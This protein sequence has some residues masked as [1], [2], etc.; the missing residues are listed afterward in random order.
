MSGLGAGGGGS[1]TYAAKPEGADSVEVVNR[2]S[3]NS[4]RSVSSSLMIVSTASTSKEF[5]HAVVSTPADYITVGSSFEIGLIGV[6]SAGNTAEIPAGATLRVADTAKGSVA[7]NVFTALAVGRTEI[8]LVLGDKVVGTKT[9]VIIKQPTAL[10]FSEANLNAVYG[11]AKELPLTATYN[12]S[13]VTINPNDIKFSMSNG[14]AGVIDGFCFVGNENSGVRNV[15]VIASLA[16]NRAVTASMSL[17]LYKA[18][19]SIFDFAN[20]DAGN[21]S[22]A[23]NRGLENTFTTD[24][25]NYYTVDAEKAVYADYTFALDMKAIQAPVR[26]QPLMEYLNG[27]AESAGDN[28]TPWDYLLWNG[29][30]YKNVRCWINQDGNGY[31]LLESGNYTFGTDGKLISK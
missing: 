28:A 29:K 9:V 11:E 1:T 31:G 22:L 21:T 15:T 23:W 2:P 25:K 27:F 17:R 12:N 13:P 10:K 3:D 26:L 6:G 16:Q 5:D 14:A 4:E 7:D 18:D 30:L 19:E 20:A 8:E 24:A